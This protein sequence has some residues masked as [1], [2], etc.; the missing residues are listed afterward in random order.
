MLATGRPI[1]TA[2]AK[3]GRTPNHDA[4]DAFDAF[5]AFEAKFPKVT[6]HRYLMAN[7]TALQNQNFVPS[8]TD[9]NSPL[10]HALRTV[11][12]NGQSHDS[13]DQETITT[14]RNDQKRRRYSH[15]LRSFINS[16]LL[17][18]S[19]TP[20]RLPKLF[21]NNQDHTWQHFQAVRPQNLLIASP[22][23]GIRVRFRRRDG[24]RC[25]QLSKVSKGPRGANYINGFSK[26]TVKE[27]FTARSVT[28]EDLCSDV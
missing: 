14:S 27:L 9:C 25:S 23:G 26:R 1:A 22:W 21:G 11:Q 17:R 15:Y 19:I 4:I 20:A 8:V 5:N 3:I 10:D 2:E 6:A 24:R 18:N 13:H 16:V 28:V 12:T 7:S